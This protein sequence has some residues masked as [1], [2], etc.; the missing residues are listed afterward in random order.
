MERKAGRGF[1]AGACCGGAFRG[2][3][4]SEKPS[5]L[6]IEMGFSADPIS[7]SQGKRK[8]LTG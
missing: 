3:I 4:A 2:V 8:S 1:I 6:S 5:S 7:S